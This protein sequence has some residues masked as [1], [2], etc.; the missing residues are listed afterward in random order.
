MSEETGKPTADAF[1]E[2]IKLLEPMDQETRLRCIAATAHFFGVR[3]RA[4]LA[5]LRFW[6]MLAGVTP[7]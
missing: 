1:I 5:A 3:P 4:S 7:E 2:V 6:P